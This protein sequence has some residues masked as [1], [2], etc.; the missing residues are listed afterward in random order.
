MEMSQIQLVKL[1]A[2]LQTNN[3]QQISAATS[4]NSS[5]GVNLDRQAYKDRLLA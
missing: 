3:S 1:Q 4:V 2:K 5:E